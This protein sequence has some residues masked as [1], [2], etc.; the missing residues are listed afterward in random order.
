M[1]SIHASQAWDP[2]SNPGQCNFL[3][4]YFLFTMSSD[5]DQDEDFNAIVDNEEEEDV[6]RF[7]MCFEL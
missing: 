4:I 7:W 3:F 1:V 2:S 5:N 6:Y